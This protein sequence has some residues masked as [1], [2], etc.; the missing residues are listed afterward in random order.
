MLA[1]PATT[2][3]QSAQAHGRLETVGDCELKARAI[4]ALMKRLQPE[5]GYSPIT[6]EVVEYRKM[7]DAMLL[8]R[9][10]PTRLTGRSKLGQGKRPDDLAGILK[11]LWQRGTDQDLRAIGMI[12]AGNQQAQR[13]AIL[14]APGGF[15]LLVLPDRDLAE[16]AARLLEHEY[17]NGP[18]D[19]DALADAQLHSDAWIGARDPQ[20]GQLIGTAA[21]LANETKQAFIY[22]VVVDPNY[23]SR[24]IGSAMLKALLDHPKV[25]GT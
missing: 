5:G 15:E 25:R 12:L 2:W 16:Q 6:T 20:T 8:F 21:A 13:P 11:G 10:V 18:Y 24:G 9:L 14:L 4:G 1:C 7:L 22:D 23:Q 3:F 19:L 17:W